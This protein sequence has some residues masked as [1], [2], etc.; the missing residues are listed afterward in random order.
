MNADLGERLAR[1]EAQLAI[2]QLAARYA[3]GVDSRNIDALVEIFSP[4]ADFGEHGKG[5]QG[6]RG[7]FGSGPS[8]RAFYRSLHQICGHVIELI[9]ADHARGTVYCRA[10]HEDGD[11]WVVQLMVYFDQYERINERWVFA[12]RRPG[13]LHTGDM[14]K[15]PQEVRFND[16]PG[17]DSSHFGPQ[18][19]QGYRTWEAFW[20]QYPEERI[21]RTDLP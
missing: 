18:V 21:R 8:L 14:R 11:A 4:N 2:Q 5:E 20:E 9:D 17:R 10:E 13:W 12:G 15:T 19:P 6:V 7:F 3:R 16:W 1:V